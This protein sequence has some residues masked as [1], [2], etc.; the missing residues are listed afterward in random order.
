MPYRC[1]PS[2]IWMNVYCDASDGSD[3]CDSRCSLY[4]HLLLHHY[5]HR[6]HLLLH[7]YCYYDCESVASVHCVPTWR[8][9]FPLQIAIGSVRGCRCSPHQQQQQLRSICSLI[10]WPCCYFSV[11]LTVITA[12]G[13]RFSHIQLHMFACMCCRYVCTFI[14]IWCKSGA[15]WS[16]QRQQ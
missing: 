9:R 10:N 2:R 14:G 15:G 3:L 8:I 12:N 5:H 6:R 4:L 16:R 13:S 1:V 11:S 7:H